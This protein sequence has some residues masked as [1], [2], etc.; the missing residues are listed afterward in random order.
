DASRRV[1]LQLRDL[2]LESRDLLRRTVAA[3]CRRRRDEDRR[4]H[5]AHGDSPRVVLVHRS[6][7]P[8]GLNT[9]TR[10]HHV[11]SVVRR[12]RTTYFPRS[13]VG[14]PP[15]IASVNAYRP[16]SIAKSRPVSNS[17]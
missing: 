9:S 5:E 4:E 2:V 3:A 11:P 12:W 8:S 15:S 6:S 14:P 16:I 1:R 17:T 10:R 7:L 13:T